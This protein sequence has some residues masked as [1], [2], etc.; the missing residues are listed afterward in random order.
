MEG[1]DEHCQLTIKTG[2][3]VYGYSVKKYPENQ[4]PIIKSI[5]HD[6]LYLDLHSRTLVLI[7]NK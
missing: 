4:K 1:D 6:I 3:E 7:H 5:K 2:E